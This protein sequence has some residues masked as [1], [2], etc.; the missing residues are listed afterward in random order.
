MGGVHQC[1]VLYLSYDLY[2]NHRIKAEDSETLW[3][4]RMVFSAKS[5][6]STARPTAAHS[7][8][9]KRALITRNCH[10]PVTSP[11]L[12]AADNKIIDDD[13]MLSEQY[14]WTGGRPRET[15]R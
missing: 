12:H 4:C 2:V 11:A 5:S 6:P 10:G 7:P 8:L 13:E 15:S 9:K 1:C 14:G 3:R